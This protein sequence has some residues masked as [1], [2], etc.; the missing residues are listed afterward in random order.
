MSDCI[1]IFQA[2]N[3]ASKDRR[4]HNREQSAQLLKEKGIQFDDCNRGAHLIVY[5]T[6]HMVDFWPGTGKWIVRKMDRSGRGVLNL[7]KAIREDGV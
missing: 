6:N 4:A 1:E 7:I 3:E 2:M 5:G